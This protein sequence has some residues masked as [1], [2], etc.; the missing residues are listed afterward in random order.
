M[1]LSV[2]VASSGR[3]TLQRT[4]DSIRPQ[5]HSEDELLLDVNTDA[6]WGHRARNR[7][8]A[9]AKGDFLLFMDD[10]DT[11]V[12]GAFDAIRSKVTRS[13]MHLFKMRY[14]D[15]TELWRDREVRCGNVSTQMVVVPN[16]APLGTWTDVYEGDFYFISQTAE[17]WPV[18]WHG[19]V[20]AL[21]RP[22]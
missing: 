14:H 2:I 7:Q 13:A 12:S 21:I 4:L 22:G 19:D 9:V 5:L 15:G 11:Y 17:H 6:P 20:I 18:V 10:D 1:S 8:M 3:P 16:R